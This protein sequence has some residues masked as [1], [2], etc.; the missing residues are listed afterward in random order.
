MYKYRAEITKGEEVRYI[1]HLDY[2][3]VI[4]R[5]ICRAHLPAAYSEGF[6]PHMK[7]AFASAL[8]MGVTS[9]KEYMDFEMAR[10]LNAQEVMD[11]LNAHL[12]QGVRIRRIKP[13]RE[14]KN[15]KKHKSL[16]AEVD[17]ADY[18]LFMPLEGDWDKAVESVQEF[19]QLTEYVYHRVTP[20]KVRDI[21]IKQYIKEPVKISMSGDR[22]KLEMSIIITQTGTI[23][24]SDILKILAEEFGLPINP[25]R[26]LI[27]RKAMYGEG[28]ALIDLV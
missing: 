15:K 2:A 12:P 13:V 3:G 16:M 11:R 19:N 4:Q 20:K 14:F 17:L 7:M 28:K 8:A 5:A 24:S 6:N 21:E 25:V 23:K 26:A 1:S 9:D 18:E 10:P 22:L 27:N